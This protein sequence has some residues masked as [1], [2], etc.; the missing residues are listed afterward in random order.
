MHNFAWLFSAWRGVILGAML[1]V[2]AII[3]MPQQAHAVGASELITLTNIERSKNGLPTLAYNGQLSSSA[4][5][6]AQDMLAK[7]YWSHTSP[8]GL[9]AWT[10]IAGSGY[11]YTVAGENLANGFSTSSG[12]MSGWMASPSHR[13]NILRAD[14]RDVGVAVVSGTLLGKVTT[15]V[16]A[17]Y[18]STGAAPAP[19]PSP[20]PAP[21]RATAPVASAPK[22]TPKPVAATKVQTSS[23]NQPAPVAVEAKTK[24]KPIEKS[25]LELLL[26]RLIKMGGTQ[27]D[28]VIKL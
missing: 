13:A 6:K 14:Y 10:F 4:Y 22:T 28:P 23:V 8:D 11:S 26:D 12:V 16:V 1:F 25:Q 15:L 19:A 5:A 9:T 21:A 3:G 17:H 18:G 20:A 7:G 24:P 27:S 2:A